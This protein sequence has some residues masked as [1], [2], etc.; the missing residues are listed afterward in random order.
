MVKRVSPETG[1]V[2]WV[3]I[4]WLQTTAFGTEL[5][6]SNVSNKQQ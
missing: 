6:F 1:I 2:V 5:A 4:K 3:L